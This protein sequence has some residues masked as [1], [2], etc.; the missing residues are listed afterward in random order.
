MKRWLKRLGLGVLGPLLTVVAVGAAWEQSERRAA[1]ARFPPQGRLVDIGGRHI[2]IDCRGEGSPTVVFETNDLAGSLGWNAV[3]KEVARTARACSYSRA[4]ILW[5]E[6]A[7]GVRDARAIASDLHDVLQK[8]SE[9]GPF[10]LV[11]FSLGGLYSVLHAEYFGDEV[12]GLVLVDSAH[13]AQ[14]ARYEAVTKRPFRALSPMEKMLSGLAWTGAA[15]LAIGPSREASV[16]FAP[17]SLV[18]IARE[19]ATI[20]QTFADAAAHHDLGARPLLVL[21]GMA[22]YSA[23]ALAETGMSVEEGRRFKLEWVK[24]QADLAGWSSAGRHIQV[25]GAGHRIQ[26][27]K[28]EAVIQA[29]NEVVAAVRRNSGSKALRA[30]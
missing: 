25:P 21:T 6:P 1:L 5:S 12:A 4:G 26:G 23:G 18:T 22:P 30:N 16:A 20:D 17:V 9:K 15:R 8:A 3:Q 28:P 11:G 10:V 19:M 24:L 7:A 2:Q 29:V 14:A 13:P 27:D